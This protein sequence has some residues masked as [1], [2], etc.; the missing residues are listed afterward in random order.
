MCRSLQVGV[1]Q[2]LVAT[3]SSRRKFQQS[4]KIF[5]ESRAFGKHF[6]T[7]QTGAAAPHRQL[8]MVMPKATWP[9]SGA[10]QPRNRSDLGE[11][12]DLEACGHLSCTLC[13]MG[14]HPDRRAAFRS[15]APLGL[16]PVQPGRP[17]LPSPHCIQPPSLHAPRPTPRRSAATEPA[18]G[19]LP[20]STSAHAHL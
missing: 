19:N 14:R 18:G 8:E 4:G 1:R 13:A 5:S 11:R 20:A 9:P 10:A 3:S 6:I 15:P 12:R 16:P 17:R 7:D 2:A